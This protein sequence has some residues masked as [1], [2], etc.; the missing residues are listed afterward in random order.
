MLRF[1][2][3]YIWK[4]GILDGFAGLTFCRLLATYEFLSVAKYK[5]LKRVEA[6]EAAARSLSSVPEVDWQKRVAPPAKQEA[7]T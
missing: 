3:S 7:M 6:D 5:E 2:Y 1:L 4:L